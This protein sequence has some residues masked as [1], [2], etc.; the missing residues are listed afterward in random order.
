MQLPLRDT[1]LFIGVPALFALVLSTYSKYRQNKNQSSLY[2]AVASSFLLLS[3]FFSGVPS[4]FTR[5]PQT[6]SFYSFLG[7]SL[8]AAFL[9]VIWLMAIKAFLSARP[10]AKLI[11]TIAVTVLFL[12][13]VVESAI[14][15]LTAPYPVK[16]VELSSSAYD[17]VFAGGPAF[18]ILTGLNFLA[19]IFMGAYLWNSAKQSENASQ[20]VRV[21]GLAIAL[22]G[23]A[24][25]YAFLPEMPIGQNYDAKDMIVSSVYLVIGGS[26]IIGGIL[27]RRNRSDEPTV[28][29]PSV[30]NSPDNLQ[31]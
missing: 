16:V 20:K 12:A 23:G 8:Q 13:C 9:L 11:S 25:G 18:L 1:F 22:I 7:E 14:N 31:R 30:S 15:N 24:I 6:L 2:I 29:S 4:L 26:L 27:K 3:L 21:K 10:K 17:I 19:L 28:G 5:D